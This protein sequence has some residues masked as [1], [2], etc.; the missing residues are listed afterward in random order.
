MKYQASRAQT[1]QHQTSAIMTVTVL[2]VTL[3][4]QIVGVSA[5]GNDSDCC[6]ETLPASCCPFSSA[7][8]TCRWYVYLDT[9][10]RWYLNWSAFNKKQR[11]HTDDTRVVHPPTAMSQSFPLPRRSPFPPF[12][13]PPLA[14]PPLSFSFLLSLPPPHLNTNTATKWWKTKTFNESVL[15]SI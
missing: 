2:F 5:A 8:L 6:W 13:S 15:F 12:F 7:L 9:K 3:V 14:S 4:Y 1:P 10:Q 11:N